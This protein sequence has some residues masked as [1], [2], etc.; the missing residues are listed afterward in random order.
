MASA[1]KFPAL[2]PTDIAP[3]RCP[4]CGGLNDC[5]LCATGAYK[6]PCWC[7]T[8]AIPEALIAQIPPDLRNRACICRNCVASFQRPHTETPQQ[9]IRP[10]D[11]YYTPEGLL[12]FTAA[13]HLR[14]GYCCGRNC[15]HCP[16][17][18]QLTAA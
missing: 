2:Q 5:Q 13:Y 17:Q 7:T 10:E 4:L 15:R 3:E 11:F 8:A 14:R 12:V 1:C 9:P 16:F 6:G 18:T